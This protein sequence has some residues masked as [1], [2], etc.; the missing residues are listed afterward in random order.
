VG[1]WL[2]K[3]ELLQMVNGWHTAFDVSVAAT[4]W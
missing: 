4:D 1:G 2:A 3:A